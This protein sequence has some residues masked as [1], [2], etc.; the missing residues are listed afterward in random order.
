MIRL[1]TF[2][3]VSGARNVPKDIVDSAFHLLQSWR[4]LMDR[5]SED[6][7]MLI[8]FSSVSTTAQLQKLGE[9]LTIAEQVWEHTLRDVEA[10]FP[11]YLLL[12]REELIQCL[13]CLVSNNMA[14]QQWIPKLFSFSGARFCLPSSH[15]GGP[16]HSSEPRSGVEAARGGLQTHSSVATLVNQRHKETPLRGEGPPSHGLHSITE[17]EEEE[18]GEEEMEGF[19]EGGAGTVGSR[20]ERT[21]RKAIADRLKFRAR[22]ARSATFTSGNTSATVR[23]PAITPE[24]SSTDY[25]ARPRE[26]NE[27]GIQSLRDAAM[28]IKAMEFSMGA[29]RAPLGAKGTAALIQVDVAGRSMLYYSSLGDRSTVVCLSYSS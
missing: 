27:E 11:R 5:L 14:L 9:A 2:T 29:F 12:S 23:K 19:Q 1:R 22:L 6:P 25:S 21:P 24:D 16:P 3:T 28:R 17:S 10:A 15:P 7:R 26:G 8:S 20:N 4:L 13:T 18:E